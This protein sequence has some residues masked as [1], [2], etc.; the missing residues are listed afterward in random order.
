MDNIVNNDKEQSELNT[1]N[2]YQAVYL[3]NQIKPG[4]LSAFSSIWWRLQESNLRP[5]RCKRDALPAEL[6]PLIR[7]Q[8][9]RQRLGSPIRITK[10]SDFFLLRLCL[11]LSDMVGL[12]RLERPTSRLS[13]VRSN[14]LSYRPRIRIRQR[15]DNM[16]VFRLTY[17]NCGL[18]SKDKRVMPDL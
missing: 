7:G 5:S 15:T 1:V 10:S 2:P 14:Q 16:F 12:G 18:A 13:G 9:G 6:S 3:D 4:R 11:L 8:V 17:L